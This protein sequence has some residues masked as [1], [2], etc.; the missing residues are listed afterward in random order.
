MGIHV[1]TAKYPVHCITSKKNECVCFYVEGENKRRIYI[2]ASVSGVRA[3]RKVARL[4]RG[5]RLRDDEIC[6]LLLREYD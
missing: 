1:E 5:S 6:L 4:R 2:M 3:G